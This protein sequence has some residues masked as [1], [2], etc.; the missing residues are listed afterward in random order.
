MWPYFRRSLNRSSVFG[1]LSIEKNAVSRQNPPKFKW[2]D[3]ETAE[4]LYSTVIINILGP[5][6]LGR[7]QYESLLWKT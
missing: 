2:N 7:L 4:I 6:P 1:N 3:R 5:H